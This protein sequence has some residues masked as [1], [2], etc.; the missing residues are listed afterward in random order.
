MLDSSLPASSVL[1]SVIASSHAIKHLTPEDISGKMADDAYGAS[2]WKE[3]KSIKFSRRAES[4]SRKAFLKAMFQ[5]LIG[6]PAEISWKRSTQTCESV[7]LVWQQPIYVQFTGNTTRGCIA[8]S[9]VPPCS[10][11]NLAIRDGR[12]RKLHSVSGRIPGPLCAVP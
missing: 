1:V 8:A 3:F 11:V 12:R 9:V 10:N 4:A 5:I 6:R 7:R 2:G